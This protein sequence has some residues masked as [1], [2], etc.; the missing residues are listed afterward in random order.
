MKLPTINWKKQLSSPLSPLS[1]IGNALVALSISGLAVLGI[2]SDT[3]A[4]PVLI[5]FGVLF[6]VAGVIGRTIDETVDDAKEEE[7]K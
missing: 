6:G 5:W 4:L 7:K 3:V 1:L 2:I